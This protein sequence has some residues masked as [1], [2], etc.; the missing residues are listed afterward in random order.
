[1]N[2]SSVPIS[3][4][5][6]IVKTLA[7]QGY[8]VAAFC[9]QAS[10]DAELLRC[11]EARVSG[12]EFGRIME[13]ASIITGDEAFGLHFG[14]TLEISDLG[15][16]GYVMMHSSTVNQALSAYQRY[17]VTVCS[18][19]NIEWEIEQN[20]ILIH[21]TVGDS[22]GYTSWH[23]VEE[24]TSSLYHMMI[25]MSCRLIPIKSIHFMHA[26]PSDT[27]AHLAIWGIEPH[28]GSKT[29]HLRLSKEILEYPIIFSDSRLLGMFETVAEETR[30]KLLQGHM[31]SDQLYKWIIQC[32][33]SF[34]PTIK[35]TA[36][37]FKLSVRTIQAKL[38]QENT[39]YIQ[40]LNRV[41]MELANRYL[42]N[43]E[44]T[45]AEVAYLLHYSEPSAFQSAFKK[46]TGVT[47]GQRRSGIL[48]I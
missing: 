11:P 42:S 27:S 19:Y 9:K 2:D 47:P 17:N 25:R 31:F 22:F 4:I 20:D 24:M 21:I 38:K 34:I 16:L 18:A 35:D 1:M 7:L 29:N 37:Q 15:V 33:P 26:S 44:Y 32:I 40:L 30:V 10:F 41:R 36:K 23:C 8:D 12:E 39:S 45:V 48:T 13:T 46:W 43:P 6:P 5:Y 14:Q 28:F 3:L